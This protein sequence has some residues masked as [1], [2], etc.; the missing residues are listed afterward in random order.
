MNAYIVMQGETYH[1]EKNAGLIWAPETDKAGMVPH[2]YQRLMEVKKGD[3]F[4]LTS[5][6][7]NYKLTGDMDMI[8]SHV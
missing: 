4:I 8:L 6:Y 2:S 1:E 5:D 3:H 7:G